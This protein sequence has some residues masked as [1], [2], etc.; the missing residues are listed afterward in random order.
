MKKPEPKYPID[1]IVQRRLDALERLIDL[2]YGGEVSAFEKQTSI[3]MAQVGQWFS[4]YRALRDKALKRLETATRK[5][6]GWFDG[7][8]TSTPG[9]PSQDIDPKVMAVAR[10]IALLPEDR[11]RALAT[12]LGVRLC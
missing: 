8:A 7:G 5:P 4:G 11:I 9:Q 6:T 12:I 2:E 1:P 10:A 3:R